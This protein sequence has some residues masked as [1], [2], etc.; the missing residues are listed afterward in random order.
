LFTAK[1]SPLRI[2][3]YLKRLHLQIDKALVVP[4]HEPHIVREAIQNTGGTGGVHGVRLDEMPD[5][6]LGVFL[7]LK[8]RI[9]G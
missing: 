1:P 9:G 3:L 6:E 8:I 5:I 7:R 2:P 4:I